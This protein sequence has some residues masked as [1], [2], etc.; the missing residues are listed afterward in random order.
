MQREDVYLAL[1][2]Y[3][4]AV[5]ALAD[6]PEEEKA[7][8]RSEVD[9]AHLEYQNMLQAFVLGLEVRERRRPES[10]DPA[11]SRPPSRETEAATCAS[12]DRSGARDRAAA[13]A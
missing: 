4:T 11:N 12:D 3:M 2:A 13:D 6:A 7:Q 5:A 1:A 8:W 9:R 10:I